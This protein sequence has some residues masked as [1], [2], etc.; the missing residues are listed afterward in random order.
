MEK[1]PFTF[2]PNFLTHTSPIIPKFLLREKNLEG[3]HDSSF[4][5]QPTSNSLASLAGYIFTTY[6]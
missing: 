2:I 3:I 5:L 1:M 4:S 6:W